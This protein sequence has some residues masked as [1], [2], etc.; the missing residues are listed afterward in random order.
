MPEIDSRYHHVHGHLVLGIDDLRLQL[1]RLLA[2]FS[3][4]RR[5][6]EMVREGMTFLDQGM[7]SETEQLEA[8]RLLVGCA[9]RLRIFDDE[10]RLRRG[11]EA[12]QWANKVGY[13]WP[14]KTSQDQEAL[15]L[16]EA[17]N[18]VIHAQVLNFWRESEIDHDALALPPLLPMMSLY[19]KY[20]AKEWKAELHIE[21][22]V[23]IA[24]GVLE[25]PVSDG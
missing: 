22:F 5:I 25:T 13:L 14:D 9:I 16:R 7:Q 2:C 6:A 24:T 3:T 19:G 21:P 15:S 11:V 8:H 20:Y 12:T 18:K 4:S 17:C 23:N 1:Y 10:V